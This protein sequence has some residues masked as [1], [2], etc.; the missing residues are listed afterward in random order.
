[1]PLADSTGSVPTTTISARRKKL[2]KGGIGDAAAE[3]AAAGAQT[4]QLDPLDWLYGG[5]SGGVPA[6][7]SWPRFNPQ[8]QLNTVMV[9]DLPPATYTERGFLQKKSV[10][11]SPTMTPG[12]GDSEQLLTFAGDGSGP[13][14]ATAVAGEKNPNLKLKGKAEAGILAALKE[15]ETKPFTVDA[16]PDARAELSKMLNAREAPGVEGAQERQDN[17]ADAFE[18][19]YDNDPTTGGVVHE[20][21]PQKAIAQQ[22]ARSDDIAARIS[23]VAEA[24]RGQRIAAIGAEKKNPDKVVPIRKQVERMTQEEYA[25]LTPAQRSAV[26]F[27]ALLVNAVRK[28]RN[29]DYGTPSER[30]QKR[31]DNNVRQIFGTDGGS[32]QY[33]PET[34]AVL[35]SIGYD[36]TTTLGRSE[37]STTGHGSAEGSEEVSVADLDD[38]LNLSAGIREKDLK[39]I[40]LAT[41]PAAGPSAVTGDINPVG[42]LQME[43]ISMARELSTGTRE[44][45]EE[46]LVAAN[47]MLQSFQAAAK[48]EMSDSAV[49]MGG[50]KNEPKEMYGYGTED[51]D[52]AKFA[53]ALD[54]L[55][56]GGKKLDDPEVKQ[57]IMDWVK[58]PALY[59][60]FMTYAENR[61]A[62]NKTYRQVGTKEGEPVAATEG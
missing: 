2:P 49:L 37:K 31:Y 44:Y 62:M 30:E 3:G 6:E 60:K 45:I 36:G 7:K 11:D 20:R 8:A 33:A 23:D 56:L 50:I 15:P 17:I 19:I 54:T 61:I 10:P 25:A 47:Q 13:S 14:P 39:Y 42:D 51:P 1:M 32:D 59:R 26:D 28:D 41:S 4:G 22:Q 24:L 43:R 21:D 48:R 40:D 38:F 53:G 5:G 9:R 57:G 52:E 12:S 34:V 35:K 18:D 29:A 58:D 27:N 16:L 46:K 55:I